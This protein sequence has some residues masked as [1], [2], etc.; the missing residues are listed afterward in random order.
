MRGSVPV[1]DLEVG[2][3]GQ[4]QRSAPGSEQ[5][6][7][8]RHRCGAEL[9]AGKVVGDDLRVAK[10]VL[11]VAVGA[12]LAHSDPVAPAVAGDDE[13]R[14]RACRC[15]PP[16]ACGAREC[17]NGG[18]NDEDCERSAHRRTQ[19]VSA[20]VAEARGE[21]TRGARGGAPAFYAIRRAPFS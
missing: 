18:E 10:A 12:V 2:G 5:D 17:A 4:L 13:A 21:G 15:E 14:I 3:R 8:L 1:A 11:G 6:A 9:G 7:N 19:K 20:A 16:R